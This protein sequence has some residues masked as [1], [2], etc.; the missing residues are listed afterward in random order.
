[1]STAVDGQYELP[2]LSVGN[3]GDENQLRDLSWQEL[4]DLIYEERERRAGG[5]RHATLS[6]R[7]R[8]C[9]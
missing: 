6:D 8:Y 1:M 4:R 3:P 5:T 9:R 2:D 7:A